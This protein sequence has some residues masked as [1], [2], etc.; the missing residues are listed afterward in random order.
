M[1]M[2]VSV[3]L[4]AEQSIQV[5]QGSSYRAL[6]V[7]TSGTYSDVTI[8]VL[9]ADYARVAAQ[10]RQAADVLDGAAQTSGEEAA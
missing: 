9:P 5:E 8:F 4:A 10:L 6:R 3:H 2:S 1:N 7:G